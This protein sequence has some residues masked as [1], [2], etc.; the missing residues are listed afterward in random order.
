MNIVVFEKDMQKQADIFFSKCFSA[1]G[2]PYSP[3]DR[4][5]DNADI[6][7]HYMKKGCFWC[8]R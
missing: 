4:H 7:Q 1:V 6:E 5:A 8:L 2:I 3:A